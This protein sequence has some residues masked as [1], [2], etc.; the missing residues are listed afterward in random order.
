MFIDEAKITVRAGKGGDGIVTFRREKYEPRGGPNGGQGG[1]GGNISLVVKE[2]MRT[3]LDFRYRTIFKADGGRLGLSKKH[4]GKSGKHIEIPVPPG[5][6]V[7]D[8][9]LG[10]QVADLVAVGQTLLVARGG[11]GGLGNSSFATPSRQAPRF[12]QRGAPGEQR[13]LRLELKL[14]ADVGVIGYPSVGKSSLISVVSAAKP[15]IAAY[16]FTTLQPHLGVVRFDD[17]TTFV[18]ADMPGL[19]VGAHQGIGLGDQFL[20]HIERTRLIVH[21]LDAS[22]VEGRD[23]LQDRIDI[24][25]ELEL[26]KP[27]LAGVEQ[28]VVL[29]KMD[30]PSARENLPGLL[31]ALAAEQPPPDEFSDEPGLAVFPISTATREGIDD[32]L[33]H[34]R[35]RLTATGMQ[36]S[37]EPTED[38]PMELE[39]APLPI[40]EM[41][42]ER[43]S[44]DDLIVSG[45]RVEKLAA[46]IDMDADES[47]NWFQNQL[48]EQGV[49]KALREAGAEP[50]DNVI[51]G[52]VEFFYALSP[53]EETQRRMIAEAREGGLGD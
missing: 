14:L 23:P 9:D 21:M 6:V 11:K 25:R 42:V 16:H 24:N 7:Y 22:G 41:R 36:P 26:Y 47:L 39:L 13:R 28:I 40:E 37:Y 50:G 1:S 34:L 29:N 19:I 31:E 43:V 17:Y 51:I 27:E 52:E 30:L 8:L 53:S 15:E 35:T 10:R 20:K 48:E 33:N 5:T 4:T 45:T 49:I 46:T 32:L 3:L 38:I 18:I 2:D 12:C 44:P